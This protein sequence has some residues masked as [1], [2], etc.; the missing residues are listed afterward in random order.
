MAAAR[1]RKTFR[2][3]TENDDEPGDL[4]EE[5]QEKLI[6]DLEAEDTAK[7]EL[8]RQAFLSIPLLG[9]LVFVYTF[10][11]A[12]TARQRLIAI[13]GISSL[14]CT[15]YILHFQPLERP[16]RKGKK[17]VYQVEAEKGPVDRYLVYLNAGLALLLELDA[18]VSWRQGRVD[19]AWRESLPAIIMALTMFARQQLAPLDLED[20]Q[21][22]RYELKGA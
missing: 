9:M 18:F 12:S 1:L 22:A 6:A 15:G 14:A 16:E 20:L 7:N 10:L 13:L 3:P 19:D 17:P 8:Y 5:H 2:F 21:K 4:D 11:I